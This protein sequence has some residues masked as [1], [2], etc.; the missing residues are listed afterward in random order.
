VR[1]AARAFSLEDLC[2]APRRQGLHGEG[3]ADIL[4]KVSPVILELAGLG[5]FWIAPVDGQHS[6]WTGP[7]LPKSSFGSTQK[8]ADSAEF[9]WDARL[10][11]KPKRS[12]V[13]LRPK[14]DANRASP[15]T[16]SPQVHWNCAAKLERILCR[17]SDYSASGMR[18]RTERPIDPGT[19]FRVTLPEMIAVARVLLHFCLRRIRQRSTAS[20]NS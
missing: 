2:Q 7:R 8:H 3:Q 19:E 9:V 14:E 17:I 1:V 11:P 15:R 16:G 5:G 20:A 4:G 18:I 13:D 12:G 10:L 6:E